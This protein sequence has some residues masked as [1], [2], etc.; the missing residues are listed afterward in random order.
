MSR[1]QFGFAV[2]FAIALVWIVAGFLVMLAAVVAG[3]V[4]FAIARVLESSP[5][6][7]EFLDRLAAR[8][9]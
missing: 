8:R 3:L 9:R 6:A 7:S 2:G 5:E 4:G 1:S